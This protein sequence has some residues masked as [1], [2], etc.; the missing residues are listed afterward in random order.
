[1][2]TENSTAPT[3]GFSWAKVGEFTAG[4]A[5]I[6]GQ[7]K[8]SEAEADKFKYEAQVKALSEQLEQP[9]YEAQNIPETF[10]AGFV[11]SGKYVLMGLAALAVFF[12]VRKF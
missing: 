6:F 7:V 12:V 10:A 11:P 8:I 4:L 2:E 1:M 5:G 3:D 9:T